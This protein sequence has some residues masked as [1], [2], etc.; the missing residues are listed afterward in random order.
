MFRQRVLEGRSGLEVAE[1]LGLSPSGVSR[2]LTKVR[3]VLRGHLV[4]VFE[5]YSFTSE[6]GDELDGAG[7]SLVVGSGDSAGFDVALS[8]IYARLSQRV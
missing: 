5:R 6:E 4:T 7:L 8:E 3:G 2:C 1:G